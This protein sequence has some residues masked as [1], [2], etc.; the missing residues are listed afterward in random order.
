ME[1]LR[2]HLHVIYLLRERLLL[3]P[4]MIDNLNYH[5]IDSHPI[6]PLPCRMQHRV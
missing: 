5:L 1:L 3:L 6:K 4:N 2:F